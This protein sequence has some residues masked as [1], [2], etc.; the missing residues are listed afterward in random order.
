MLSRLTRLVGYKSKSP[1]WG[2]RE[3]RRQ[4][5]KYGAPIIYRLYKLVFD[6]LILTKVRFYFF[7][8]GGNK[9]YWVV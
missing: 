5:G 2:S 8:K 3:T 4:R 9:F 1:L 6:I 7:L